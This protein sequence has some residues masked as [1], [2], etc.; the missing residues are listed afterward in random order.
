M[1]FTLEELKKMMD[2]N[3]GYLDLGGTQIKTAAM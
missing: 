2:D 1:N 3:G